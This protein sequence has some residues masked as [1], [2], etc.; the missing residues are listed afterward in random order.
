RFWPADFFPV[1]YVCH[2]A[3]LG[4]MAL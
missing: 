3:V 1:F 2:L 4:V